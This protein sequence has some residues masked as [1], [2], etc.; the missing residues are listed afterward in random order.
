VTWV[1]EIEKRLHDDHVATCTAAGEAVAAESA[2][3]Q[4]LDDA[5]TFV[6]RRRRHDA[7]AAEHATLAAEAGEIEAI[8]VQV[9][10]ARRA[11]TVAPVRRLAERARV[12][13]DT[14]AA[15]VPADATLAQAR[16][17]HRELVRLLDAARG[18]LPLEE[19]RQALTTE[20]TRTTGTRDRLATEIATLTVRVEAAP[21]RLDELRDRLERARAAQST[22]A[23]LTARADAYAEVERLQR[24]LAE[25]VESHAA[26]RAEAL[27]LRERA[28]DVRAARL[29]GMAAE[30]AGA[31]AAGACCPVCGSAEHPHKASPAADAPGAEAERAAQRAADDASAIEHLRELEARDLRTRLDLAREQAGPD[32]ERAA[33]TAKLADA[34]A[35]AA[36]AASLQDQL[37]AA[38]RSAEAD[39]KRLT[40]ANAQAASAEAALAALTREEQALA[41]ALT[42]ALADTEA[43][44]ITELLGHRE[45]AAAEVAALVEAL[46]A[47]DRAAAALAEAEASLAHA[48]A[49]AGFADERSA[50]DAEL[51]A[52]EIDARAARLKHHE[53]RLAVVTAVLA[54]PG[55]DDLATRALPDLSVLSL[56]HKAALSTMGSAQAAVAAGATTLARLAELRD[57]LDQALAAWAPLQRS[58]EVATRLASFAE[59]K[60][61]DNRLQMS[62]SAYV[63]AYRLT[64]VVAAA[65]ERLASMSD[66][67]YQLEHTASR[68]A[69]DRRGGLAL[70][71]RDDWSGE[72]RDP[73]T[74]SGGET[75]VVSLALALGLA[76]VIMQEAGGAM[77]DTLFVDEGFGSLDADTL[78]DVLDVLDGLRDGGR[79]VG[80]VSHVA[81][82]RDRIPAQ[83]HVVKSRAGSTVSVRDQ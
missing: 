11:A 45:Q 83:L 30:L 58:L 66:Q 40:E 62:L 36:S 20:I 43:R 78:D 51:D 17:T 32:G 74:L 76:D 8:A 59:G 47:R 48:L 49:E 61:A 1:E 41:E 55:A 7:A 31:L 64:Q 63:V 67:R 18:L 54:E 79:V 16:D 28:L 72:A 6:E 52:R 57:E 13:L 14:C 26:A 12:Q 22:A 35:L 19:R 46:E 60:S 71:V 56:A 73:A 75:F 24:A 25:A 65:N 70:I 53:R 10:A 29:E 82:M 3:R 68:A 37:E 50:A 27:E 9:E 38:T 2:A 34:R 80:V 81:E 77:L 44:T 23:T 33:V 69:G 15:A 39:G 5:R 42:Q 4:A 21:A